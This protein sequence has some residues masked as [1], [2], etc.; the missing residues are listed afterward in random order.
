MAASKKSYKKT[1]KKTD[2]KRKKTSPARGKSPMA[3]EITFLILFVFGILCLLSV[4]HVCGIL[5][6]WLCGVLFG[7]IG[8]LAY[9]FPVYLI[10]ASGLY[11]SNDKNRALRRKVLFSIG[12]FF[13]L[14]GLFQWVVNDPVNNVWEI[15]TVSSENQGGGGFL[16][17]LL[18]FELAR[19]VGRAG[20]FIIILALIVLFFML[21]SGKLFF[22]SLK[23]LYDER[24]EQR[25]YT[26]YEE[27]VPTK[28][29]HLTPYTFENKD[30][31]SSEKKN[32]PALSKK[33]AARE[34]AQPEKIKSIQPED[35]QPEKKTRRTRKSAAM[36]EV[37][38]SPE[39]PLDQIHIIGGET[40]PEQPEI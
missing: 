12:L 21:I 23:G 40:K 16:G 30:G 26:V 19:V 22:T 33:K 9:I 18:A 7:L 24:S 20:S 17:G 2:H 31:Q 11:I 5:G 37:N 38:G 35:G 1:S 29:R 32:S 4:F 25:E 28:P 39:N 3:R 14:C 36:V 27:E 8:A 34:A 15:Y 10:V 6:E 13:S